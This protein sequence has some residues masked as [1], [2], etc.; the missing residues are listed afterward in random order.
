MALGILQQWLRPTYVSLASV[1]EL[2]F[3]DQRRTQG[4]GHFTAGLLSLNETLALSVVGT[5]WFA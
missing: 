4:E 1:G 3:P 2:A 5:R